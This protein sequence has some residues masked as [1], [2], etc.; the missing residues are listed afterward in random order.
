MIPVQSASLCFWT[1]A[2]PRS[3]TLSALPTEVSPFP[4]VPWQTAH[5]VL[6]TCSPGSSAR[7]GNAPTPRSITSASTLCTTFVLPVRMAI[8]SPPMLSDCVPP[9]ISTTAS[10][11]VAPRERRREK[12]K[13]ICKVERSSRLSLSRVKWVG[14][15]RHGGFLGAGD[16]QVDDDRFLAAA[17]DDGFDRLVFPGVELLMGHVRRDV[18]EVTGTGF[19]YELEAVSPAKAGAAANDVDHG[20]KFAVMVRAG[21]GVGVHNDGPGPEFLRA[22]SGVGDGFGAR[23]AA[24]L[25][26]VGIQLAA[27]DDAQAVVSP[28]GFHGYSRAK[29]GV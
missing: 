27:A 2:E 16:V 7:E 18:D 22:G 29:D 6:Y 23:H 12:P 20:F 15:W 24:G 9:G 17:H 26:R 13:G 5:F 25:R 11:R 1:S 8:S 3:R 28:V 10:E 4:S 21:L 14:L 19:V